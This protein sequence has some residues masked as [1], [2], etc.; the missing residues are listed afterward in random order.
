ME[1]SFARYHE[2]MGW[3]LGMLFS[4]LEAFLSLGTWTG[5]M[6]LAGLDAQRYTLRAL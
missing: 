6:Q 4:L 1:E 3:S 2:W 5:S